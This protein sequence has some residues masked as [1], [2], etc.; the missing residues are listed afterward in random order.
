MK[1]NRKLSL[2]IVLILVLTISLG[3][4]CAPQQRPA[5]DNDRQT[6]DRRMENNEND[7]DRL[8]RNNAQKEAKELAE[9]IIDEVRGV[10]AA[11]VIFA[12]EIAYVGVDLYANYSGD[13]AENV[14]RRLHG[15]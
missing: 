1:L 12:D 14:K 2:L 5:P 10:N 13:A 4:A 9:K 11:T 6:E 3:I 8:T 15:L 7:R